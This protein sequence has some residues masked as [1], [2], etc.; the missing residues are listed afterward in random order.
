MKEVHR[1]AVVGDVIKCI[2]DDTHKMFRIGDIFVIDG[3]DQ[4]PDRA[5]FVWGCGAYYSEDFTET[6]Y[7]VLEAEGDL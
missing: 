1:Q 3:V 2:V 6:E 5:G 7:V 4:I